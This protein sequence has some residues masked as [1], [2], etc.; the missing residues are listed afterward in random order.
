MTD[1]GRS[2]VGWTNWYAQRMAAEELFRDAKSQ[3]HGLALRL[4]Q[5]PQPSRGGGRLRLSGARAYGLLVGRGRRAQKRY[6]PGKW[7]RTKRTKRGAVQGSAWTS[8]RILLGRMK[9]ATGA[10]VTAVVQAT[11]DAA[12]SWG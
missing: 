4:P 12:P 10:A 1:L 11:A 6:R 8:G 9:G 7:C 2:A 5:L 3:R